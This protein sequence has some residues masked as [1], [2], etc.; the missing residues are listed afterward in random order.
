MRDPLTR[1]ADCAPSHC[2]RVLADISTWMTEVAETC[3]NPFVDRVIIGNK[4]DLVVSRKVRQHEGQELAARYNVPWFET[5]AWDG[6]NVCH[7]FDTLARLVLKRKHQHPEQFFD[8][9]VSSRRPASIGNE[10]SESPTG[11]G[12][13]SLLNRLLHSP[14]NMHFRLSDDTRRRAPFR[15]LG[16]S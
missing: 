10:H 15:C 13:G 7:A 6:D 3:S 2:A 5:S 12:N 4:A 11:A 1:A 16:S 14:R 9:A 8:P